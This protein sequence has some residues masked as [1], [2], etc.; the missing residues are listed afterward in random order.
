[1]VVNQGFTP[2][3]RLA[4]NRKVRFS[5]DLLKVDVAGFE[6]ATPTMSRCCLRCGKVRKP[7]ISSSLARI[8]RI[9]IP[10]ILSV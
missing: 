2:H 5:L 3:C 6:P 1:M 9:S 4:G 7:W 8:V 10:F